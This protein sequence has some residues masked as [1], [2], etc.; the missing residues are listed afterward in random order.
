[1]LC[2]SS[3]SSFRTGLFDGVARRGHKRLLHRG[4]PSVRG[5]AALELFGLFEGQYLPVHHDADAVAE[6]LGLTH[7]VGA[8]QYRGVVGVAYA[9]D[10]R[11]HVL[12]APGVESRSRLVEEHQDGTGEQRPRQRDLLLHSTAQVLHRFGGALAGEADVVEDLLYPGLRLGAGD[13]V[14][15]GAVE[16]I[17]HGRELL[18]EACLDADPVHAALHL[19][20]MARGVDPEY[21]DRP[22]VREDERGDNSH[23]RALP[24]PV[25]PEDADDLP[26]PDRERD[27]VKGAY[28]LPTPL[29]ETLRYSS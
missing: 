16:Q 21:L 24:A 28:H 7:V 22:P 12:L 1:M 23:Q 13:A 11:L 17:L 25:G 8:E 6:F 19:L 3:L 18:E 15:L 10:E 27:R 9:A 4:H 26:F 5:V 29:L 20:G 2:I 14:E